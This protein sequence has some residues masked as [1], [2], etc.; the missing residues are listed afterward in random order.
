[1]TELVLQSPD[2]TAFSPGLLNSG[3]EGCVVLFT[4]SAASVSAQTRLLAFDFLIPQSSD[5]LGQ[6]LLGAVLGP[7]FVAAV[8]KRAKVSKQGLVF[9]HSHP[10]SSAPQFSRTDDDGEEH[11]ARF[12][13]RRLPGQVHVALVISAGGGIARELGTDRPVRVVGVVTKRRVLFDVNRTSAIIPRADFDRQIR[14][15]G[16]E[17]QR[18]IG[19]LRVGTVGLGG[20]GS[21][22]AQELAHLG[23]RDFLLIDADTV[24]TTNLNRLIGAAPQDVGND[25]TAIARR[26]IQQVEPNAKVEEIVGDV[27]RAAV[28]RKLADM[29]VFFG[30]TD[31]H[32][33]RAIMQQVAYQYLVPFI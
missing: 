28:A 26:R 15:F 29:D 21:F 31:S 16:P 33:S 27:M 19:D 22:I 25:K 23:V 24:D 1:M 11:L 30:C 20:T 5:Y 2:L 4:H 9:I 17:G 3:Q 12:L 32:G 10:G 13:R 18:E 7:P 14:A 6:T 8:T